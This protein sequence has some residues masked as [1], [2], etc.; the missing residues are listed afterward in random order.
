MS[1]P[2]LWGSCGAVIFDFD[3]VLADSEPFYRNT[4]NDVLQPAEPIP[5]EEYWYRWSFMGEAEQHL[6]EMGFS[7][8]Q[9]RALKASQKKLYGKLCRAGAVPL[10]PES[11]ALLEW[12]LDRKPCIIASNT[13]SELVSEVLQRGGAPSPPIVGG[14][15]MKHKP[16]PD[17]FL[18]ASDLLGFPPEECLVV[19]DAWK[20]LRAAASGGFPAI[21]VR[22]QRNFR[23]PAVADGEANGLSDLLHQWKA[24]HDR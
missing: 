5:E 3:G 11:P 20:G 8:S 7:E 4:W 19:E 17:I 23:F 12:V 9:Q 15:G 6:S 1:L 2:S 13:D 24:G 10:F 16:F 18:K 22:N 14:E 21:L